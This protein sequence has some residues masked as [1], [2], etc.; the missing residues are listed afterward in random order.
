MCAEALTSHIGNFPE[1]IA[2]IL[3]QG[4]RFNEQHYYQQAS[5]TVRAVMSLWGLPTKH[6]DIYKIPGIM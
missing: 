3:E 1:S 6:G 4:K 5:E 2:T